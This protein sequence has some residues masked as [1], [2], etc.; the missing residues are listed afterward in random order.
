MSD[1]HSS[2]AL[3]RLS[4]LELVE[5]ADEF[6]AIVIGDNSDEAT[7]WARW[8]AW[9]VTSEIADRLDDPPEPMPPVGGLSDLTRPELDALRRLFGTLA[10]LADVTAPHL[11]AWLC[12]LGATFTAELDRMDRSQADLQAIIDEKR[13][14]RPHGQPGDTRGIPPWSEISGPPDV[15]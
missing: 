2:L 7:E 12:A 10:T 5:L 4:V 8:W 13:R 3:H 11:A 14:H 15:E 1:H 6:D 9:R